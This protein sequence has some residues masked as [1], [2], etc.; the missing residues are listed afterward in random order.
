M[1]AS[2]ERSKHLRYAISSLC[3]FRLPPGTPVALSSDNATVIFAFRQVCFCFLF[4]FAVIC[5]YR[6]VLND[7]QRV[8][9]FKTFEK[10][11]CFSAVRRHFACCF[12]GFITATAFYLRPYRAFRQG[13]ISCR[14]RHG[15]TLRVRRM[16]RNNLCLR[17]ARA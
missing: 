8:S 11:S 10:L 1:T 5:F 7:K 6:A 9:P 15:Y 2:E 16:R 13:R 14:L 17:Q 12:S 3:S 4:F